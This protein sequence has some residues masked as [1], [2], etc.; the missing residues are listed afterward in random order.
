M[1]L[2]VARPLC[3]ALFVV[4]PLVVHRTPVH[5]PD[6]RLACAAGRWWIVFWDTFNSQ[7][8]QHTPRDSNSAP[9]KDSSGQVYTNVRLSLLASLPFL[10]SH[11]F[12]LGFIL[13]RYEH[14]LTLLF[15]CLLSIPSLRH[16]LV[17]LD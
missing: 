3:C 7:I 9:Q 15:V 12:L 11:L 16:M 13:F 10:F 1:R 2:R 17:R 6:P 5:F 4:P 14:E 8:A